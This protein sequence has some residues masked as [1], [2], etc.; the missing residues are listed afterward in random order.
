MKRFFL[1]S[2]SIVL[3]LFISTTAYAQG[4]SYFALKGGIFS[5]NSEEEGLKDFDRGYNVEAAFGYKANPNLAIEAG[6]GYYSSEYSE[7]GYVCTW[8]GCYLADFTITASAIP[9]TLTLKGIAPLAY[10]KVELYGG[11]GLGYY[12]ATAEAEV[13]ITGVGSASDS[14]DASALGFHLVGVG[15]SDSR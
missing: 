14:W 1:I 3:A 10:G 8:Y 6:I 15:S 9:I 7:S 5:P 4:S 13:A 2:I 11:G 12:L